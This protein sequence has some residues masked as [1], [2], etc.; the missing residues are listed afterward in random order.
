MIGKELISETI[1]NLLTSDSAN[2]ALSWMEIFK[3]SHLPVVNNKELLGV[4]SE[5][6]ILD[7]NEPD[8]AIGNHNLSLKK[9]FVYEDEHIYNIINIFSENKLTILPVVK[10]DK[11]YIGSILLQDLFFALKEIISIDNLGGII[12]LEFVS[13]NDISLTEIANIVEQDGYKIL[14]VYTRPLLKINKIEVV[15]KINSQ[16]ITS[17]IKSF[18]RFNYHVKA[19]YSLINKDDDLLDDRY[20]ELLYFLNI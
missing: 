9:I 12:V 14:S 20:N 10:R 16:D 3:I 2:K 13:F 18:E 7:L 8:E 4:I 1:P 5:S 15:L 19:S 11:E 17:V 6:D